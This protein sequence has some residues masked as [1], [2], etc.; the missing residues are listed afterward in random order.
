MQ[1]VPPKRWYLP[2]YLS[3]L[4]L[5]PVDSD[6]TLQNSLSV[7]PPEV[8]CVDNLFRCR[9]GEV[10]CPARRYGRPRSMSSS[11]GGLEYAASGVIF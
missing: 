7:L 1:H 6:G 9:A 8:L 2:T 4:Y 11:S 3:T 10:A 5:N